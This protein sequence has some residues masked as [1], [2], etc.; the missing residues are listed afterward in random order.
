[1][2]SQTVAR[3]CALA[4]LNALCALMLPERRREDLSLI[5]GLLCA[6]VLLDLALGWAG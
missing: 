1:M 3:L 6:G 4:A 5:S 2:L